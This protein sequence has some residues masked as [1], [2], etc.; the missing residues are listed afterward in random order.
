MTLIAKDVLTQSPIR[1]FMVKDLPQDDAVTL[2]LRTWVAMNTDKY[3]F[4]MINNGLDTAWQS[5]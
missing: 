3:R 4:W 2:W 5:I 1:E